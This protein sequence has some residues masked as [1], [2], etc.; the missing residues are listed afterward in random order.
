MLSVP[1][2]SKVKQN[3]VCHDDGNLFLFHEFE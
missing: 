2:I 1:R 3:N